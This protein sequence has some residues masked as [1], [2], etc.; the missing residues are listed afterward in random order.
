MRDIGTGDVRGSRTAGRRA[1]MN[2]HR[3]ERAAIGA[4]A[5][6]MVE[7]RHVLEIVSQRMSGWRPVYLDHVA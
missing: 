3:E 7:K 2:A 6:R 1:M 5:Y 4:T